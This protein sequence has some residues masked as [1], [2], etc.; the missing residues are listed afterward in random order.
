MNNETFLGEGIVRW[1][2]QVLMMC[3]RTGPT[4]GKLVLRGRTDI[5]LEPLAGEFFKFARIPDIPSMDVGGIEVNP[6]APTQG[7]R[8]VRS[9]P[10]WQ[11]SDPSNHS[12]SFFNGE[13]W[14]VS[15]Q[16]SHMD[17][18]PDCMQA[19]FLYACFDI[20]AHFVTAG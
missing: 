17:I 19:Q 13:L 6:Q 10:D 4:A 8:L 15:H 18:L 7:L 2:R 9:L 3:W 11:V 5:P 1:K 14:Q 12:Q 16:Q 20:M